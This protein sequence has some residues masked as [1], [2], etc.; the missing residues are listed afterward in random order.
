MSFTRKR[1]DL[2]ITLGEGQFGDDGANTVTLTG[3]RVQ[4]MITIPG[5]ESMASAQVR[6]YG[7]PISMMNQ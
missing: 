5:G 3:M 1:I 7:L 4:S 2:T 6:V